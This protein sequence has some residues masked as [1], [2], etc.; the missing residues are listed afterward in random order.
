MY[1]PVRTYVYMYMRIYAAGVLRLS[2]LSLLFHIGISRES[3]VP[4]L[5]RRSQVPG[6][7][8]SAIFYTT[9]TTYTPAHFSPR[10]CCVRASALYHVY[11]RLRLF[12]ISDVYVTA[13]RIK[14]SSVAAHS[15]EIFI[16]LSILDTW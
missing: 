8:A 15:R 12:S 11:T 6:C 1:I 10:Q 13:Q 7:A 14:R 3:D 5:Y 16:F 2:R 9:T 4:R